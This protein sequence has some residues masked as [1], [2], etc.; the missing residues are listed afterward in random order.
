[1]EKNKKENER[2]RKDKLLLSKMNVE[3]IN[4]KKRMKKKMQSLTTFFLH[5][6]SPP[7]LTFFPFPKSLNLIFS[8]L[9]FKNFTTT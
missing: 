2:K 4:Q 5:L 9:F 3:E 1:M 7:S 8:H 6:L